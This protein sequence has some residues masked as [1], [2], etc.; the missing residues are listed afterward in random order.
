MSESDSALIWL[1]SSYEDLQAFP[2]E[3]MR[4]AGFELSAVQQGDLPE[5]YRPMQTVGAGVYEIKIREEGQA[6]RVFYVAKF[7]GRVYVLHA[8]EKKTQKTPKRDLDLAARRYR[9]ALDIERLR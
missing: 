6:F 9:E 7:A 2:R 5:H 4:R 1:G 3:A 8:M